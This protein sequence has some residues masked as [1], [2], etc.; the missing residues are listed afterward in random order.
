MGKRRR[1]NVSDLGVSRI[2]P[3]AFG[4]GLGLVVVAAGLLVIGIGWNGAAG[5]GGEINGVPNLSAQLP[6]LL[7]GGVLGLGL[8]VFGAALVIVHNA[9]VDRARLETKF[10]ELVDAFSRG[11][12]GGPSG[13]N[14]AT[15]SSAAGIYAA[16]GTSYHR[17]DCRLVSGRSDVN[18]VT[19]AEVADRGLSACRVCKPDT[20]E[21]VSH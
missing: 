16:G 15:P 7:S 4:G 11:A 3:G 5:A 6:W 21:V 19:G 17:P 8:V 13:G 20:V 1:I 14:V 10:D 2:R 9:R 18:Y 12:A